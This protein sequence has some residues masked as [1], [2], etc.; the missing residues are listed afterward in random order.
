MATREEIVA[1]VRARIAGVITAPGAD[2]SERVAGIAA[3]ALPAFAARGFLQSSELVSMGSTDRRMI[4]RVEVAIWA[5]QGE[6]PANA[7]DDLAGPVAAAILGDPADLG[8]LV[9]DIRL[10][11]RGS[12]IEAGE[13]RIARAEIAFDVEHIGASA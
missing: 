4:E 11:G 3:P 10:A 13:V 6:S 12:E 8:G 9:W 5:R 7:A 2:R 1:A